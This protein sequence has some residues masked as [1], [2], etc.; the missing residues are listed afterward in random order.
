MSIVNTMGVEHGQSGTYVVCTGDESAVC[1]GYET[2]DYR[3]FKVVLWVC[4]SSEGCTHQ[5]LVETGG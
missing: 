1:L 3:P 2:V 5:Q 4:P